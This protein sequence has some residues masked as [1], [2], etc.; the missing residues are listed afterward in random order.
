MINLKAYNIVF[1]NLISYNI[2][3]DNLTTHPDSYRD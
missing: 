1:K 3:S 2:E